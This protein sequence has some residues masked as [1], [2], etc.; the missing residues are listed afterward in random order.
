MN[1]TIPFTGQMFPRSGS[2]FQTA[3]A[4]VGGMVTFEPEY[5]VGDIQ[6]VW[7]TQPL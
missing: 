2:L 5:H 1:Q 3:T 4:F 7:Q 6:A